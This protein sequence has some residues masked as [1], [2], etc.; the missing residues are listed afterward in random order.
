MFRRAHSVPQSPAI[1]LLLVAASILPMAA[2]GLTAFHPETTQV[3]VSALPSGLMNTITDPVRR[4]PL[5]NT[6][7]LPWFALYL[8]IAVAIF[9]RH[10]LRLIRLHSLSSLSD[11]DHA[12]LFLINLALPPFALGGPNRRIVVSKQLWAKLGDQDRAMLLAHERCHIAHRDPEVTFGLLALQSLFWIN[13]GFRMLV[14]GWREAI[15]RRADAAAIQHY[16]R[17][18]YARLFTRLARTAANLPVPTQSKPRSKGDLI[19]RLHT[20]LQ[21]DTRPTPKRSFVA[22]L[23]LSL[24]ASLS[25]SIAG[26]SSPDAEPEVIK[27]VPPMMP[28]TCP[29]L[30]RET[31]GNIKIFA[32]QA[33]TNS[34]GMRTVN[35]WIDVGTV[36]LR[37][38]VDAEGIPNN[39]EITSANA[40]CFRKPSV[41]SVEQWVYAPNN[42]AEGVESQIKFRL[43]IEGD[44]TVEKA[45]NA[46]WGDTVE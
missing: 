1:W 37:Y 33:T 30:T 13:P 10:G 39:I 44:M 45:L 20:I 4:G 27:R 7:D 40:A 46:F 9:A 23:G 31:L 16:D 8:G 35:G 25:V 3:L 29:G 41:T 11:P 21:P 22:I 34:D 18:D 12:D 24:A 43:T 42:P 5:Q 26:A 6:P 36:N 14:A 28:K 38:D 32:E 17:R 2:I 15:E 19:M